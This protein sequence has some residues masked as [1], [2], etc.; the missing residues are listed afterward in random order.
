MVW[1]TCVPEVA[2]L[3]YVYSLNDLADVMLQKYNIPKDIGLNLD[4]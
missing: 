3:Y 2:M 4:A 1:V